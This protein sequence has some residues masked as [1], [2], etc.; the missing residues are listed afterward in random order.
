V[1]WHG[2][3]WESN[4]VYSRLLCFLVDDKTFFFS[5]SDKTFFFSNSGW[6]LEAKKAPLKLESQ[7]RL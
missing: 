5:N 2:V 6:E 4:D 7:E 3:A 1:L